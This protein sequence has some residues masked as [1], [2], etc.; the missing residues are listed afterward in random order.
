[1]LFPA[2]LVVVLAIKGVNLVLS[3]T[4]GGILAISIGIPTGLLKISD[5]L[6]FENGTATGSVVDGISGFSGL[7]IFIFLSYALSHIMTASGAIDLILEKIKEN[8]HSTQQAELIN[9]C[10]IALSSL[11]LCST[12]ASQII[13]GPNMICHYTVRQT[14]QMPSRQCSATQCHGE[15]QVWYSALP[16]FLWRKPTAGAR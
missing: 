3:M 9:C 7:I 5:V 10:V 2:T 15:G 8:I 12:V 16:A 13:A 1:M 11:A 6:K 4:A 14:F